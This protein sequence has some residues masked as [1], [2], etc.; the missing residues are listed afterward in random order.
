MIKPLQQIFAIALLFL[1]FTTSA[2]VLKEIVPPYNIKT[3]S[4]IQNSEN[5]YPY[6]SLGESFTLQ[7]DD[8]FGN[9]ANYYYTIQ[10]LSLI[11]I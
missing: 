7:F 6:F 2:Q 11:H 3:V 8:L 9:E 5:V 1:S 4:F 10:H